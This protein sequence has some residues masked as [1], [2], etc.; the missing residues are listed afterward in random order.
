MEVTLLENSKNWKTWV[1]HIDLKTCAEC[2]SNHGKIYHI[3]ENIYRA[4]PVHE[5]CRCIIKFLKAINAGEATNNG[6]YGADWYLKHYDRLP[7]YYISKDETVELG[8]KRILGNLNLVA[9]NKMIFGGIY[10][11]D[12]GKLPQKSGRIWYEADIN[13]N[14]G[15]R[16]SQRIL[17]SNDGLVFVTY[18]YYMTFC[19]VK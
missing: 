8:W 2:I 7:D 13:Y 14:E 12:D 4:P 16:N 3:E 17:F 9:P 19:E 6:I 1:A 11:N 18:N 5:N 15:Y 10:Y